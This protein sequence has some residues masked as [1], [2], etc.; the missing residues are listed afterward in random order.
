MSFD[1][2]KKCKDL[3][4]PS[5]IHSSKKVVKTTIKAENLNLH[6]FIVN[7]SE[8]GWVSVTDSLIFFY[9]DIKFHVKVISSLAI[10]LQKV[11]FSPS[12]LNFLTSPQTRRI[13]IG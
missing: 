12:G 7:F 6:M 5:L 1:S 2:Q 3:V 9:I 10:V 11:G 4:A 8:R 13:V